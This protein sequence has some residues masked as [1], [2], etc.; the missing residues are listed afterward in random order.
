MPMPTPMPTP[1]PMPKANANANVNVNANTKPCKIPNPE[2]R[3]RICKF[4]T[5]L[6][7]STHAARTCL[8]E[9]PLRFSVDKQLDSGSVG[10]R[11]EADLLALGPVPVREQVQHSL[12][13]VILWEPSLVL[14]VVAIAAVVLQ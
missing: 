13:V 1:T 6:Q 7:F 11:P 9:S 4:Q 10:E 2:T 8:V 14:I 5:K 12:S 3:M